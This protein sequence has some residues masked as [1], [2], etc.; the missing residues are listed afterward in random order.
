MLENRITN[1]S[2][3]EVKLFWTN[4]TVQS[5]EDCN[6][7]PRSLRQY[8]EVS[9]YQDDDVF[10]EE[11]KQAH[12]THSLNL[13][14]II[15]NRSKKEYDVIYNERERLKTELQ[16]R[17]TEVQFAQFNKKLEEKMLPIQNEVKE[18]KRDKFLK[19]QSGL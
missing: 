17:L 14:R 4:Q 12:I 1:L 8:K 5:Y 16:T 2:E 3:K 15:L 9:Q 13:M 11:W 18:H 19:G 10:L 7:I 6:R